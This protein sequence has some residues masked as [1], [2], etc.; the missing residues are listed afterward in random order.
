MQA[1]RCLFCGASIKS[2]ARSPGE[3]QEESLRE[4]VCAR[5]W[6]VTLRQARSGQWRKGPAFQRPDFDRNIQR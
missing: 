5:C 6:E 2:S 4:N 3:A 1:H